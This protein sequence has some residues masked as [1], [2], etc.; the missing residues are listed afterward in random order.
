MSKNLSVLTALRGNLS[1]VVVLPIFWLCFVLQYRPLSW[2]EILEMEHATLNFN[3]TIIMCI[4]LGVVLI[5]RGMLLAVH[6]VVRFTWFRIILW[7]LCELVVMSMFTA[8]YITLMYHGEFSYFYF[9]GKC[10]YGLLMIMIYPY[11]ILNLALAYVGKLEEDNTME[12]DSLMRFMDN[13]QK[14]KLVIASSAVLYVEADENYVH[15]RYM[16]GDRLKDYPLR[17]SMKSLEEL[18]QKH[19]LLRCQRSYYINPQ[20]I[21]VLRRDKEGLITAE[22]DVA[23]QKSIPVSPKYYESVARWL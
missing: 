18:M 13:T 14:L 17:A 10:L 11:I 20:H 15:I 2:P 23:N 6:N 22:L 21:K 3:A 16:E 9:V 1:F 12:D 5:S 7:E 19:G 8:L 4:L